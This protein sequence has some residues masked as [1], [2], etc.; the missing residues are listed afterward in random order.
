L[1]TIEL[2]D[3]GNEV[4]RRAVA[5]PEPDRVE[6]QK[7]VKI[8]DGIAHP[9]PVTTDSTTEDSR[10]PAAFL[11]IARLAPADLLRVG[12]SAGDV[13]T[14]LLARAVA[15]ESRVHFIHLNG[16]AVLESDRGSPKQVTFTRSE[17]AAGDS[18]PDTSVR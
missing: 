11:A 18:R 3:L 5:S 13:L 6:E 9:E 15:A 7:R 17:H 1:G 16:P 10:L 8:F 2:P 14:T 12:A 4:I